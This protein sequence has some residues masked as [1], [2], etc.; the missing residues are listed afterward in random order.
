MKFTARNMM[1]WACAWV[2]IRLGYV[3]KALEK[4]HQGEYIISFYFH[5]P[6]KREFESCIQW[7][8]KHKFHFLSIDDLGEIIEG[9]RPFPK[10]A[11]L[12]T[13]DDGW[14]SN[15]KSIVDTAI[16]YGV[17]VT[18]FVSTEPVE[19]GA[20]WWSYASQAKH[21]GHP[22]VSR[23][24]LKIIPNEERLKYIR[25]IQKRVKLEREAL[26]VEQVQR[27]SKTGQ[28]TIGGHT[29][30]H[31]ILVNC[32]E[33]SVMEELYMSKF[34]LEHWTGRKVESFAYPNGDYREREIE[35][36]K[37]LGYRYAFSTRPVYLTK[38]ELADRYELPRFGF[39]EGGS[40]SENVCRMSGVWKFFVQKVGLS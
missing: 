39:L 5:K 34:K 33:K 26:T 23:E 38:E 12:I 11:V 18:I 30:T 17:P 3:R 29:H 9:K 36:L 8:L 32:T 40:F 35:V 27:I 28:V 6:T 13:V 31:P 16:K 24:V 15:E 22:S 21:A 10:G 1:A 25:R 14:Q 20:Y 2:L 19:Q 4:A 37:T 7:F